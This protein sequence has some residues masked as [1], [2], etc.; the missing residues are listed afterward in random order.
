LEQAINR[1]IPTTINSTAL[2]NRIGADPL[3]ALPNTT[4]RIGVTMA[5]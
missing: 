1:M 5:V 3:L 2:P 4:S